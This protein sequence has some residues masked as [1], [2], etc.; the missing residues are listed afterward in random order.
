MSAIT[1]KFVTD[2]EL[3]NEMSLEEFSQYAPEIL[4]LLPADGEKRRQARDRLQKGYNFSK[5]QAFALIPSQRTGRTKISDIIPEGEIIR[6]TA[7]RIMRDS[8]SE[9]EVKLIAKALAETSPNPAIIEATKIPGITT[10]SNKIQK[11]KSLLCE[12][13]GIHYPDHFS[14]E[15]VKERL[16]SYDVSNTPD[17]QALADVMIMLCIRPAEIKDLRISNGGVTGYVKNRDQQDIPRVFRSLEKNEE[18]AKQLLT[19]I[20][21]AIS[22]GQLGDPGT[23]RTGILSRFLKKAEFLPETGKPL[24]PSSLCNLGAVFVVVASRVRNLSK[25]NTIASQALRH[26]PKNN[27]APSQRYTIV[28]YRLRG[29]PYDQANP[30]MFFDE[31]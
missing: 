23:S 26:S 12:D 13:K 15:S 21:E 24:L 14:L 2:H 6:E 28:N 3:T 18:R 29:M 4:E 30:F 20:Q 27:T 22:S 10:L 11:E 1:T 8:L 25:A 5:E 17:K 16:D 19:W 31:N 9:K 7:Q